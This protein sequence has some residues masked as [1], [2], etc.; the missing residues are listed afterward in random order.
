MAVDTLLLEGR[1][2]RAEK[3]GACAG[4]LDT[5]RV[6]DSN[7]LADYSSFSIMLIHCLALRWYTRASMSLEENRRYK[8]R[9]KFLHAKEL[10]VGESSAPTQKQKNL[11]FKLLNLVPSNH[12]VYGIAISGPRSPPKSMGAQAQGLG[13]SPQGHY[14]ITPLQQ[15]DG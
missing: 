8:V 3:A 11:N 14:I 9:G 4:A 7:H 5:D 12:G 10:R 2:D 6:S 1:A 15:D 13:V